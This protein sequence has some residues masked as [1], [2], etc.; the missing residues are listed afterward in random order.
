MTFSPFLIPG[1]ATMSVLGIV[2][3]LFVFWVRRPGRAYEL[4]M[5]RR[6]AAGEREEDHVQVSDI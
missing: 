2:Y 4:E 3:L 6:A 5:R 1:V